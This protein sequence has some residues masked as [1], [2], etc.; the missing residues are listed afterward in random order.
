M[1]SLLTECFPED[2]TGYPPKS[3]K[4]GIPATVINGGDGGA[5]TSAVCEDI[6]IM[7][8]LSFFY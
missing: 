7:Q 2:D 5:P 3:R 8:S 1:I 4:F 6:L